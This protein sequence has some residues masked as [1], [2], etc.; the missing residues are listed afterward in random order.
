MG[1]PIGFPYRFHFGWFCTPYTA[2]LLPVPFSSC[3]VFIFD[4][5][6]MFI[7]IFDLQKSIY[8]PYLLLRLFVY[9]IR[10]S[11]KWLWTVKKWSSSM[12]LNCPHKIIINVII[13]CFCVVFIDVAVNCLDIVINHMPVS[14]QCVVFLSVTV[15]CQAII[16]MSKNCQGLV[17]SMG[18]WTVK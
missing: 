1:L 16:N 14:C 13:N 15:T 5:S 7:F 18:V 12:W 10:S 3:S 11:S 6:T 2:Y 4:E 8:F 17:S 9:I